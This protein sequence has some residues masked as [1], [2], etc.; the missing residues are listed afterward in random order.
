MAV[1]RGRGRPPKD[2]RPLWKK[3]KQERDNKYIKE[4][5]KQ[6][7]IRFFVSS[8]QDLIEWLE[9]QPNKTDYIRQLIRADM[10]KQNNT[11]AE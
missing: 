6:F 2:D 4:L 1:K 10:E 5:T 9:S 11:K 7:A 3:N 8:E